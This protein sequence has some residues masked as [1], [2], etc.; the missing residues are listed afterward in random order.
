MHEG[1]GMQRLRVA[2]LPTSEEQ[3]KLLEQATLLLRY[4][5][6]LEKR[7]HLHRVALGEEPALPPILEPG[8]PSEKRL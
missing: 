1:D 3:K 6:L 7:L 2:G 5:M 8:K 4:R